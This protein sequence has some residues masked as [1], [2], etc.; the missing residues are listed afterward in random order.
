MFRILFNP[1]ACVNTNLLYR[2]II[3]SQ[4]RVNATRTKE[5]R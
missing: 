3:Q 1:Q 2:S 4:R 5:V